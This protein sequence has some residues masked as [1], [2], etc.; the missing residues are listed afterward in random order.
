M[1]MTLAILMALGIFVGVPV[2]VGL[3]VAGVFVARDRQGRKVVH[4]K[5]GEAK[6]MQRQAPEG[7]HAN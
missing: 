1:E 5:T 4:F 2:V 7:V 6:A 3:A